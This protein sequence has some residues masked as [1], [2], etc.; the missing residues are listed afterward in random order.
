MFNVLFTSSLC[1][2]LVDIQVVLKVL[3]FFIDEEMDYY[4]LKLLPSHLKPSSSQVQSQKRKMWELHAMFWEN[5]KYVYL[6]K[7]TRTYCYRSVLPGFCGGRMWG[8]SGQELCNLMCVAPSLS[9]CTLL[10][11]A[12]A[13]TCLP[14]RGFLRTGKLGGADTGLSVCTLVNVRLVLLEGDWE[15]RD[16]L[17]VCRPYKP[18][19]SLVFRLQFSIMRYNL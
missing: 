10:S 5:T 15:L 17:S 4:S 2:P 6:C 18:Y 3:W 7:S 11:A 8:T 14:H 13:G 9:Y 16:E 1:K 12:R 19:E